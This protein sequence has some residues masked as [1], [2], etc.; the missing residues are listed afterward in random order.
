MTED[1]STEK[2]NENDEDIVDEDAHFDMYHFYRRKDV[3][4]VGALVL[5]LILL[6]LYLMTGGQPAGA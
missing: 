3:W 2:K 5:F 1:K 6:V 4:L